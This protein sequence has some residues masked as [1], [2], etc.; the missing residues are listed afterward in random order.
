MKCVFNRT[1]VSRASRW[2]RSF[3]VNRQQQEL[4]DYLITENR[5]LKEARGPKRILLTDDQRPRLA[6]TGK[7][8]GR[9]HLEDD[10]APP[11]FKLEHP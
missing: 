4:I 9:K 8:L 5:V 3:R 6:V 7:I 11:Q 1:G 2:L 10:G